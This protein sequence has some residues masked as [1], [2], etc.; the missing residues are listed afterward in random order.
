MQVMKTASAILLSIAL[1]VNLYSQRTFFD[2]QWIE[3]LD[4]LVHRI[5]SIHP[6]PYLYIS[7]ELFYKQVSA[8]KLK[9]PSY[10]D[11][12]I[13]AELLH[14]VT[15]IKDGHTRLHGN[16]LT[17]KWYPV[18]IEEFPDGYFITA[19]ADVFKDA[20]GL[21]VIEVN[22]RKVE[23]VFDLIGNVTPHDNEFSRKYFSPLFFMMNSVLSGL[24][25]A[26][27]SGVLTLLARNYDDQEITIHIH[28]IEYKSEEDLAWFW[29]EYGVPGELYSNIIAKN[30]SLPL[31]LKNYD[32]PFW[33]EYL[34]E[35]KSVYFAFNECLGEND[36]E[37]FNKYLW[38]F[39]D[40]VKAE[41]LIIDLR[42]NFGGS[43]SILQPLVHEIIRH[44][45]INKNGNLFVL[46]G[47]KTFSAAIHCAAWIEY[48]CHPI[49]IGEPT[50]AG[51]NH[52]ADPD[53]S[54]LP[55]SGIVLMVSRYFWQNTWPWDNRTSIEPSVCVSLS[56]ND[57]FNYR[58]PVMDKVLEIIESK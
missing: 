13:I 48:H 21:K 33:F 23:D 44:D 12:E 6:D 46:T 34:K 57:Y 11:N 25:I 26:D 35:Y 54:L 17:K 51:P 27:S 49:F 8:L 39:I 56:S 53:F 15:A 42:N 32:K 2:R 45:E 19:C 18:R 22:D 36:F 38:Q 7:K 41:C 40:S 30:D 3:D 24:H 52:F 9:I 1:Q 31:Y 29:R 43:N 37:N 47:R 16:N 58:D 50:G 55:N 10:S 20:I 4:F 5:D 14:I 28:P